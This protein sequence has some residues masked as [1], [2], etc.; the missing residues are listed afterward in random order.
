MTPSAAALQLVD[1]FVSSM[2]EMKAL[3]HALMALKKGQPNVRLP[4]DWTGVAGKVADAFNQVVEMNERLAAELG[5]LSQI[6]R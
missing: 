6:G 5:R 2:G 1:E 4:P 3:L